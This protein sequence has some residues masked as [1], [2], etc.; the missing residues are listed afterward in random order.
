MKFV[1]TFAKTDR[2]VVEICTVALQFGSNNCQIKFV[3]VNLKSAQKMSDVRLLF[4]ALHVEILLGT[5]IHSLV[6]PNW[7]F[8]LLVPMATVLPWVLIGNDDYL[9]KC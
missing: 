9:T 5:V 2:M 6:Q 4:H 3:Q 1:L 7:Y 8:T